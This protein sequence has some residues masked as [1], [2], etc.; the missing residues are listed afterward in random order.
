[1]SFRLQITPQ[2]SYPIYSLQAI[3]VL[4]RF[5]KLSGQILGHDIN[6]SQKVLNHPTFLCFSLQVTDL[7]QLKMQLYP[8]KSTLS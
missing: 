4:L 7:H 2:I 6:I 3:N 5:P 8:D 1:M